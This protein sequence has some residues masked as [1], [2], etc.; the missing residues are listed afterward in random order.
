MLPFPSGVEHHARL[1][2]E[3]GSARPVSANDLLTA[4]KATALRAA[5]VVDNRCETAHKRGPQ[6]EA[7]GLLSIPAATPVAVLPL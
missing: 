3:L 6:F 7:A 1:D 5:R 2:F 4:Q